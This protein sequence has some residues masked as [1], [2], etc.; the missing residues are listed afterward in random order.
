[1]ASQKYQGAY[2][3]TRPWLELNNQADIE[4]IQEYLR[5]MEQSFERVSWDEEDLA[6]INEVEV[7]MGRL[8]EACK[9]I[10]NMV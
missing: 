6:T 5:Q 3:L 7:R 9:I 10:E 1:M 8:S 4:R 2:V